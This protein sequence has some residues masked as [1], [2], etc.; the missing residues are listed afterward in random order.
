MILVGKNG[1]VLCGNRTAAAFWTAL[2]GG[3]SYADAAAAV[4]RQ[5]DV[6]AATARADLDHMLG[7]LRTSG[8][9]IPGA[10]A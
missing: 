5:Y 10:H 8:I 4:A 2:Q 3:A 7:I 1:A 9:D 6:P